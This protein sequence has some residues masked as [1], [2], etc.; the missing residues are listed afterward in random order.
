[1]IVLSFSLVFFCVSVFCVEWAVERGV[2]NAI[3]DLLT[4]NVIQFTGKLPP[5]PPVPPPYPEELRKM[6]EERKR[7]EEQAA[8]EQE[9]D[10]QE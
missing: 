9:E 2:K 5:D 7:A 3:N 1:M 6:E 10:R 4:Q 8:K